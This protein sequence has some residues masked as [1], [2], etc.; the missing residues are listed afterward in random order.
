MLVVGRQRLRRRIAVVRVQPRSR[1]RPADTGYTLGPP[2]FWTSRPLAASAVIAHDFGRHSRHAGPRAAAGCADRAAGS[3]RRRVGRSAVRRRHD[4]HPVQPLDVPAR[5]HERRRPASRAARDGVGIDALR[6][7][8]LRGLDEAL[9]EMHLPQAVHEDARRQR[10]ASDR[11]AIAPDR[12]GS[13]AAARS[14][15]RSASMPGG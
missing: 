14:T 5:L 10:I 12:A 8:V 15:G 1:Y 13:A 7:E 4:D 6:A 3:I 9:A 11:T 2:T